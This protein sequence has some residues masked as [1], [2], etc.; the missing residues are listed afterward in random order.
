MAQYE[1]FQYSDSQ[2]PVKIVEPFLVTQFQERFSLFTRDGEEHA[3]LVNGRESLD[4]YHEGSFEVWAAHTVEK[5]VATMRR[6]IARAQQ[7]IEESEATLR[8]LGVV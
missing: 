1:D 3:Q 5:R 8:M 6:T 2:T 7:K 4:R